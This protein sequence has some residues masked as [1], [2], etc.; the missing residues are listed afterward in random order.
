MDKEY[1]PEELRR[2]HK[3]LYGILEE[4]IRVCKKCN[5]PYFIQGGTAI[6]A[7]FEEA[8]LPWDDDID[9]GMTRSN[10]ER[11]LLEAPKELG[12][13]YFLQSPITEVHTPFYFAKVRKHNTLFVEKDFSRLPIHHGIYVDVFPFDKVTDNLWLQKLHRLICNF[14]NCCFMG[15]EVWMWKHC[16]KCEVEH[17]TNRGVVPCFFNRVVDTLFSKKTI[18]RMLSLMQGCF[19]SWNTT[20]YNMVLMPRDHISVKDI[21][22]PQEVSFGHLRVVAPSDL[23]TYLNH[24]YKNLRRYIPKEE[25]QNHRPMYLSFDAKLEKNKP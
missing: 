23:K 24:H 14:L 11:F 17:P 3:E 16:G 2:L 5:I 19:N 7:F 25:Q 9:V 22:H 18:Y 21:E 8:I 13:D 1:T 4:I 12:E 20:Y 15:K 6:G 10:Y